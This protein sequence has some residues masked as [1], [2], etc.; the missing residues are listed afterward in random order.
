MRPTVA[1]SAVIHGVP[2]AYRRLVLRS[3]TGVTSSAILLFAA[4]LPTIFLGGPTSILGVHV[5]VIVFVIG[6]ALVWPLTIIAIV[7]VLRFQSKIH[8]NPHICLH[9]LYPLESPATHC[10]E[11]GRSN[12]TRDLNE[13]WK[14][15]IEHGECSDN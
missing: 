1:K 4:I 3:F 9:C 10:P 5:Y 12:N 14:Q 2:S 11:C 15:I 8:A 13:A 6:M 7:R